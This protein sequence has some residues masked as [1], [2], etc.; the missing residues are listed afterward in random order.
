MLPRP[1]GSQVAGVFNQISVE[2]RMPRASRFPIV[3]AMPDRRSNERRAG[4][5]PA[6]ADLGGGIGIGLAIGVALGI[7]MHNLGAGMAIGMA[8]GIAL[9]TAFDT[10]RKQRG[11]GDRDD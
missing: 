9:S 6:C 8:I 7:P 2:R 5:M 1:R 3:E 4:R 11:A 10:T